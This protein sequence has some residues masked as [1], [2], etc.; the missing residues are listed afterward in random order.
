MALSYAILETD[1]ALPHQRHGRK[2]E[3][4]K[5]RAR[6][7][8]PPPGARQRP[9]GIEDW[10]VAKLAPRKHQHDEAPEQPP[11]PEP[12]QQH[13]E[14]PDTTRDALMQPGRRGIDNVAAV[15]L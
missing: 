14:D 2:G 3:H 5:Q 13:D 8:Q 1:S 15:E 10:R 4:E 12:A 9:V 7:E 11:N 6:D